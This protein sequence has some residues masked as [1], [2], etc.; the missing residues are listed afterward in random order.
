MCI[1]VCKAALISRLSKFC[2]GAFY[3]KCVRLVVRTSHISTLH[4]ESVPTAFA[5]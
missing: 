2:R 3:V 1:I 5:I 4:Q